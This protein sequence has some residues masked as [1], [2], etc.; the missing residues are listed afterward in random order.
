MSL[1]GEKLN[2]FNNYS[3][4]PGAFNSRAVVFYRDITL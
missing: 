4:S 2:R 1:I 3:Y